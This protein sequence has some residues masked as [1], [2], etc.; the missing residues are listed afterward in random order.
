[1][2]KKKVF[3]GLSQPISLVNEP[4]KYTGAIAG[5]STLV[6][7]TAACA[8]AGGDAG[9]ARREGQAADHLGRAD[10]EKRSQHARH[11]RKCPGW[12]HYSRSQRPHCRIQS[13][14]RTIV[15]L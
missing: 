6:E 5:F 11:S 1:M 2:L 12:H 10:A 8:R 4:G 14:R 7:S 15:W 13:R 3:H 9:I